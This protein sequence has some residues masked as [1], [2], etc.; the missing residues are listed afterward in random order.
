MSR[1]GAVLLDPADVYRSIEEPMTFSMMLASTFSTVEKWSRRSLQYKVMMELLQESRITEKAIFERI[2][3]IAADNIDK[4]YRNMHDD[5][6]YLYLLILQDRNEPFSDEAHDIYLKGCEIASQIP[7]LH[8]SLKHIRYWA[9][10]V[11]REKNMPT[12]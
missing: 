5:A 2:E 6:I 10:W 9:D 11:N 7:N 4:Q 8:W 3:V 1:K 12:D